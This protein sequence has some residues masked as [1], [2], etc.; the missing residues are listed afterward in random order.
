VGLRTWAPDMKLDNI[1]N[2]H[3]SYY[4]RYSVPEEEADSTSY[5]RSSMFQAGLR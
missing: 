3:E 1:R 2:P 4:T 5:W